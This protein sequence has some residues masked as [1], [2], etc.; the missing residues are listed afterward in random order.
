MQT[1]PPGPTRSCCRPGRSA[2]AAR[3]RGRLTSQTTHTDGVVAGI[4]VAPTVLEHLG[5]AGPRR[6]QGPA[7]HVREPGATPRRS[8][9]AHRAPARRAAAP[10]AGAVD[11]ARDLGRA[12][13][14]GD[15]RRRPP[16]DALGVSRRAAR[17]AV[18]AVGP[19][20]DGG[21][22]AVADRGAAARDG[23]RAGSRARSRTGSPAGRAAR[24]SPRSPGWPP[25]RSTSP[26]GR[27]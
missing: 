22:R 14:R 2:S 5:L 3:P 27:R 10:P 1:P 9:D 16:R 20:A 12:A 26:S 15:A 23:P 21:A 13:A 25:T 24:S 6:G 17:G 7:D 4:D 8:R 11:A 19:A 18:A